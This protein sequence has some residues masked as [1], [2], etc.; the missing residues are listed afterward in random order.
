MARKYHIQMLVHVV[1]EDRNLKINDVDP[2]IFSS[3]AHYFAFAANLS[4]TEMSNSIAAIFSKAFLH[5]VK[6]ST[7]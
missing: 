5:L 4:F 2:Y 6:D 3:Q 1:S 7:N